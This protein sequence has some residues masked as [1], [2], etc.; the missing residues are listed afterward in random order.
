MHWHIHTPFVSNILMDTGLSAYLLLAAHLSPPAEADLLLL[1]VVKIHSYW[2]SIATLVGAI[3]SEN[4]QANF[5]NLLLL[6][7]V[8]KMLSKSFCLTKIRIHASAKLLIRFLFYGDGFLYNLLS[9]DS[10]HGVWRL[11]ATSQK[12]QTMHHLFN[13]TRI[14]VKMP[15]NWQTLLKCINIANFALMLSFV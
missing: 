5:R 1:L 14:I 6:K 13:D 9:T 10:W 12:I 15:I 7:T 2:N 3:Q 8:D 11:L 4:I